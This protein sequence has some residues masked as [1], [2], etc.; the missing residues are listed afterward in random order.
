ML[1]AALVL[2]RGLLVFWGR[3]RGGS[4]VDRAS[5]HDEMLG[6]CLTYQP[7]V[8]EDA[9]RP[10]AFMDRPISRPA[11]RRLRLRFPSGA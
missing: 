3:M 2:R 8:V 4:R 7:G 9:V 10:P 11:A 6:A 5:A 1:E